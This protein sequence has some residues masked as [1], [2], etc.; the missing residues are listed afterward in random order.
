MLPTGFYHF[1]VLT[2]PLLFSV[3]SSVTVS[4]TTSPGVQRR[5]TIQFVSNARAPLTSTFLVTLVND[6]NLLWSLVI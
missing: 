2:S 3:T 5:A 1:A 6:V 4:P